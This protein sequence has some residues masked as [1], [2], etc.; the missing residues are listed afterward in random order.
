[1]KMV[2][3]TYISLLNLGCDIQS[4]FGRNKERSRWSIKKSIRLCLN[5]C[6]LNTIYVDRQRSIQKLRM[7]FTIVLR[8]I[9]MLIKGRAH[10]NAFH[11][12]GST[13]RRINHYSGARGLNVL[14]MHLWRH[15]SKTTP[16]LQYN[17]NT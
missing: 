9:I 1:M 4:C 16:L 5:V 8:D 12:D 15:F 14:P 2:C 17:Y 10:E 13:I 3:F 11:S 7:S 6:L